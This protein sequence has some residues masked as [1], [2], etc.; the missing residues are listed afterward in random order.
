M[1][2]LNWFVG[3]G[4]FDWRPSHTG[5][6][7][8]QALAQ[9]VAN[10]ITAVDPDVLTIQEGPSDPREMEL[11]V[12]TSLQIKLAQGSISSADSMAHRKRSTPW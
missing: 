6:A 12:G 3:G 7:S 5:I 1:S 4:Q 10:V 11:F 8:V 9:R 2:E